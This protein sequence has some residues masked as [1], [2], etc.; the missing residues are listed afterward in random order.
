MPQKYHKNVLSGSLLLKNS[1]KLL[2]VACSYVYQ[3][4]CS[5]GSIGRM[6][7]PVNKE[8]PVTGTWHVQKSNNGATRCDATSSAL[9]VRLENKFYHCA[10]C[11]LVQKKDDCKPDQWGKGKSSAERYQLS[12]EM[13]LH[14][15]RA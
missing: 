6:L 3:N 1:F 5:K 12:L 8:D 10:R 2:S 9:G 14:R 7:G 11:C 4:T 13:Q 15:S